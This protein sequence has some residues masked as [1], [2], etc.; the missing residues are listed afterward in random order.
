MAGRS[1]ID[2]NKV[3]HD[4]TTLRSHSSKTSGPAPDIDAHLLSAMKSL[5][6]QEL[7][8]INTT[9][10]SNNDMLRSIQ[11]QID[12]INGQVKTIQDDLVQLKR[13][14]QDTSDRI[15]IVSNTFLPAISTQMTNIASA[16]AE[17]MLDVEVHGRKWSL[18]VQGLKGEVGE[19]EQTT[20]QKCISLAKELG[21]TDAEHTRL[22]A[23]HRLNHATADAGIILRFNDLA[24]REAW[25]RKAGNLRNV[26][27]AVNFSPDLPPVLRKVKKG[28][29]DIRR[30]MEDNEKRQTRI[31]HLPRWPYVK[32]EY[33]DNSKPAIFPKYTK[34]QI[35][36]DILG[37]STKLSFNF[38]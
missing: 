8:P 2:K 21:V 30:E 10:T 12:A 37:F 7:K 20:R 29:L 35:L 16:L 13:S 17:R 4:K 34:Q 28:L 18:I 27:Q 14:T 36:T 38:Q 3:K 6:Q 22:A 1:P 25:L 15:D 5:L 32:L 23:C 31:K 24:Q 26:N 19:T 9:V 33:K 11:G